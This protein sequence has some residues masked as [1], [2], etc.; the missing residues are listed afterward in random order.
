MNIQIINPNSSKKITDD[1]KKAIK[2]Y[3]INNK[4]LVFTTA[5]DGP[6]T[7]ESS[8]DECFSATTVLETI[9]KN[10]H[11]YFDAHIIAC[12]GDPGLDAA[13]EFAD[14]PVIGIAEASMHFASLVATKFTIITTVSRMKTHTEN[15]LYKYGYDRKCSKVRAINCPVLS[16]VDEFDISRGILEEECVKAIDDDNIGAIILGCAGMAGLSTDLTAKYGIPIIDG[17][18]SAIYLSEALI[19]S[20]ITTSKHGDYAFPPEKK[21]LGK[22]KNMGTTL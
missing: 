22:F 17:V 8:F 2:K 12:F 19:N 4:N 7:I 21:Y 1:I 6:E 18:I 15:L 14:V 20:N 16:L 13:R 9:K 10:T 3:D 5:L 11:K